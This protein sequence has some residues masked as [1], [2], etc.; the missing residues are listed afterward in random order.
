MNER[1]A[2]IW[3]VCRFAALTTEQLHDLLIARQEVFIVEQQCIYSD[4]DRLDRTAIHVLG[5][6]QDQLLA[7]ARILAPG[8]RFSEASFGRVLTTTAARGQ[9]LGKT[10]I[11]RCLLVCEDE[12]P[13]SPVRISAQC[14]LEAFYRGFDFKPAGEPY[15]EDGIMH[16]DM[17][18]Q[19]EATGE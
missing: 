18:R 9:G 7:Y 2:T 6:Q 10:L 14:Y 16:V 12:F 19:P 8:A 1:S 4:A 15:D 13:G 3:R 5:Y 17:L 11:T